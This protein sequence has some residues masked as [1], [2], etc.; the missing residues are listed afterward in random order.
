MKIQH[1]LSEL[2]N[3]HD[4]EYTNP[5]TVQREKEKETD[6]QVEQLKKKKN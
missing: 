6:R 5:N 3:H 1:Q 4:Q 2:N